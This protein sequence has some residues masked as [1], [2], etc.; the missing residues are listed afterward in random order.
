MKYIAIKVFVT[1]LN[2]VG[3]LF[4]LEKPTRYQNISIWGWIYRLCDLI[5]GTILK[6]K[7]CNL[8]KI[9]LKISWKNKIIRFSYNYSLGN[10]AQN[11]TKRQKFRNKSYRVAFFPFDSGRRLLNS[12]SCCFLS[13]RV[14]TL[15]HLTNFDFLFII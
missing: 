10:L 13:K 11:S 8:K 3:C 1:F 14:I 6:V 5:L 7:L 12:L 15:V 2:A 9:Y 4:G